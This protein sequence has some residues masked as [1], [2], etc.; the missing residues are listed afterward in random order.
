MKPHVK[1][2]FLLMTFVCCTFANIQA[3]KTPKEAG[4]YFRAISGYPAAVTFEPIVLFEDGTYFEVAE[5]PLEDT[6]L[7]KS[8]IDEPQLW[9][10]WQRKNSIFTLTNAEGKIYE[11]DLNSGNWFKAFPFNAETTLKGTYEK[12]SGGNFGNSTYALFRSEIVFLDDTHFTQA[13]NGGITSF[14]S[15]AWK[16]NNDSGTYAIDKNTITFNYNDGRVLRFSFAFGAEGENILDTDMIFIGGKT[17][18]IE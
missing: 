13:E 7:A 18:V 4:W 2:L 6:D 14:S 16:N 5:E 17:Y 15:S 11:Y 12:I 10:T 1:S 3:Q 8:K 9:G